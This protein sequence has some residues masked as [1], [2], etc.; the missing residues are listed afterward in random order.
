MIDQLDAY[1][2]KHGL[3]EIV[4]LNL[5]GVPIS[6]LNSETTLHLLKLVSDIRPEKGLLEKIKITNSNPI[7]NMVYKGVRGRLSERITSIVEFENDGKFF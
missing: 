6:K 5:K 3:K 7:F 2:E 4:E 1:V